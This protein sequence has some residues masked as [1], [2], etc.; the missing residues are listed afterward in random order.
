MR[1]FGT[2]CNGHILSHASGLARPVRPF[3]STRRIL[4]LGSY[5]GSNTGDTVFMHVVAKMARGIWSTP[6]ILF[7]AAPSAVQ[8]LPAWCRGIYPDRRMLRGEGFLRRLI[9][10]TKVD[11]VI[12]A[13]GSLFHGASKN[14]SNRLL[15][16]VLAAR[17][18]RQAALGV[19][20]GPFPAPDGCRRTR[21]LLRHFEFIGVRDRR[22]LAEV[23]DLGVHARTELT[24]DLAALFLDELPLRREAPKTGR[25]RPVIGLCLTSFQPQ[26]GG[27]AGDIDRLILRTAASLNDVASQRPVKVIFF[28]FGKRGNDF[29][30]SQR[31]A[32]K[33]H[34]TIPCR[35]LPY[36]EDPY[37][38]A[39]HLSSCS[40][41]VSMRLHGCIFAYL[42]R[43]PFVCLSYHIKCKAFSEYVGIPAENIFRADSFRA[44]K[45]AER[46]I[47]NLDIPGVPASMD[48][49]EARRLAYR[50]FQEFM[51]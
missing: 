50:N 18:V 46:I 49:S 1:Q 44:D 3:S 5:G 25:Q 17:G 14:Q 43:I 41:V 10:G 22:S 34:H 39:E 38:V 19:S 32:N 27:I 20:V 9:E 31:V 7:A 47:S 12:W 33:L 35:V 48:T 28:A 13:G 21:D 30:L 42:L 2:S 36:F 37:R 45:L 16:R 40:M 11:A 26:T 8:D 29:T 23:G 24:F 6:V 15:A 4:A 51:P